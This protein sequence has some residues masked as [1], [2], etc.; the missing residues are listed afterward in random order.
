MNFFNLTK[1]Q[2]IMKKE[3]GIASIALEPSDLPV[4]IDEEKL[5]VD[6]ENQRKTYD[7][8]KLSELADSIYIHGIIQNLE[9]FPDGRVNAGNRRI[10]ALKAI[11]IPRLVREI[12]EAESEEVR[13]ELEAK[14]IRVRRVPAK[15]MSPEEAAQASERQ[16]IENLQREDLNPYEECMAIVDLL[17][18]RTD[19]GA[20]IYTPQTLAAR[21]GLDVSRINSREK[22]AIAPTK[23]LAAFREGKIGVTLCEMV[24]RI[25]NESDRKLAAEKILN[26]KLLTRPLNK[27]E[28]RAMI[29][30]EFQVSLRGA[31]FDQAQTNL[32]PE[33]GDCV[34][35]RFRSGNDKSLAVQSS[36]AGASGGGLWG[37]GGG[38]SADICL[39]P[40]CYRAKCHAAWKLIVAAAEEEGYQVMPQEQAKKEFT[41]QGGA[42]STVSDWVDLDAKPA[43]RHV[44][45]YSEKGLRKWKDILKGME[46]K[47]WKA[48]NPVTNKVHSLVK[49]RD[50]TTAMELKRESQGELTAFTGAAEMAAAGGTESGRRA[51]QEN[52]DAERER[53][54]KE[55][56]AREK[57]EA[58]LAK[59]VEVA[60]VDAVADALR[61]SPG[62]V[63]P[64][65]VLESLFE[66]LANNYADG[67]WWLAKYL[68]IARPFPG[69][70]GRDFVKPL[71]DVFAK[72]QTRL[73]REILIL[74]ASVA[75]GLKNSS[76]KCSDFIR[77]ANG[78]KVDLDGVRKA[79]E[80]ELAAEKKGKATS[81][82]DKDIIS[83]RGMLEVGWGDD[84]INP[85]QLAKLM[86]WSK[87]RALE[88][89]IEMGVRG[90]LTKDGML[91]KEGAPVKQTGALGE[92]NER[93]HAV[94]RHFA[95]ED[96]LVLITSAG[97]AL[98]IEGV[99]EKQGAVI[100]NRLNEWGCLTSDGGLDR[101]AIKTKEIL[102]AT[103]Q[104]TVV[105]ANVPASGKKKLAKLVSKDEPKKKPKTEKPI[106]W[107]KAP[108]PP[109]GVG[110]VEAA[111]RYYDAC[112]NQG[113]EI[114]LEDAAGVY[115]VLKSQVSN[116]RSNKKMLER[117]KAAK[118]KGGAK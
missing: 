45:H 17:N 98:A 37:S 53:R 102:A 72:C 61:R 64:D 84:S 26:P 1:T 107:A 85:E 69:A 10:R 23:M 44:G 88:V 117:R 11:V 12:A 76:L 94:V 8:H 103:T 41:G 16:L 100:L 30:E 31:P 65:W 40:S 56:K 118:G 75:C 55:E 106:D 66:T 50:I 113:R 101:K 6:T 104:I 111:S 51:A 99:N 96:P 48:Q 109:R 22:A 77:V 82:L 91:A 79:V 24:G 70:L 93:C 63:L 52:A 58:E 90:I 19:D 97:I 13:S 54:A 80:A 116:Y 47:V 27:E 7:P 57:A 87:A 110:P 25:P 33:V 35:C 68:C 89:H 32:I 46:I 73:D 2:K 74:L 86:N 115:G 20:R 67:A 105:S 43:P 81:G 83:A 114:S 39:N 4:W 71:K 36:S 15:V 95:A 112:I 3:N 78:L 60:S 29:A 62:G 21:T 34:G 28:A 108:T 14:L 59:A 49:Y 9:V 38:A 92:L 18:R 42:L 5:W